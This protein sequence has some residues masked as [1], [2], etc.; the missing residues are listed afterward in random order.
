VQ[1]N[2]GADRGEDDG[3]PGPRG[4]AIISIMTLTLLGTELPLR[5]S[6]LR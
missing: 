5:V 4:A 1:D 6:R 3:V 2:S